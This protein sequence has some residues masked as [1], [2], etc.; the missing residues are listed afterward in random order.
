MLYVYCIVLHCLVVLCGPY[1]WASVTS[2]GSLGHHN[3]WIPLRKTHIL[4]AAVFRKDLEQMERYGALLS[5]DTYTAHQEWTPGRMGP[6]FTTI[7]ISTITSITI[8]LHFIITITIIAIIIITIPS[9]TIAIITII[10]M[11]MAITNY[12]H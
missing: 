1:I 4:V 2:A 7:T 12:N 8:T 3:G 10:I 11:I 5:L 6:R 9:I